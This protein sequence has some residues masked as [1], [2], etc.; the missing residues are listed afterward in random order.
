MILRILV[1]LFFA[2]NAMAS[3]TDDLVKLSDMFNQGLLSQEE[4]TKAKSILLK[5]EN[6][7]VEEKSIKKITKK[8]DTKTIKKKKIVKK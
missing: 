1:F 6:I 2:S 5:I 7:E 8:K 3:V 4:F